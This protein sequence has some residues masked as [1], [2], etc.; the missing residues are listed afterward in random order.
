MGNTKNKIL[1]TGAEGF[2]GT[3]L[4]GELLVAGKSQI[5]GL[6]KPSS[7]LETGHKPDVKMLAGDISEYES[8]KDLEKLEDIKT[9]VHTA[10][11][12]H[13]F[14]GT[15]REDFWRVN[16]RGT[17]N[18]CRMAGKIGASHFILISSV[19]VYGDQGNVE[20]D[21]SFDCRPAGDYAES[22]LA[23]ENAAIE[24]CERHDVGLTILRIGTVIG[25]GDRGNTAR[26]ITTI[27][28]NRFFWIGDGSNKKSLIY[29]G[30][31]AEGICRAI[32]NGTAN[33]TEIYN[34]TAPAIQMSEVVEAI[35]LNLKKK[36][37]PFRIPETFVRMVLGITKSGI[38]PKRL[39]RVE[40]TLEKWLSN[41][42]FSGGKFCEKFGFETRTPIAEALARQVKFYLDSKGKV[43]RR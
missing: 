19:S 16:V 39:R 33:G 7:E 1:V 41:D 38:S 3:A 42:I 8:L 13:Q 34:L 15:L 24:F 30:D 2:V 35:S 26:L 25:E 32:E 31:A 4:I 37:L 10:G 29:K 22:K 43:I 18:I 17:E 12:A 5:Y 21:E 9:V 6:R 23:S 36:P 40:R 20:I 27:D 14:G 28:K 11:L